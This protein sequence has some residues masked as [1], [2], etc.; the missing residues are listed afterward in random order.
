MRPLYSIACDIVA[1]NNQFVDGNFY[2]IMDFCIIIMFRECS[3]SLFI[4]WSGK[5][6]IIY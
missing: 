4:Q 3:I 1:F 6:A 2:H 5:L